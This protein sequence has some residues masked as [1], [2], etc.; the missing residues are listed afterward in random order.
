MGNVY[1][2]RPWLKNYDKHVPHKLKYE[3]KSFTELFSEVVSRYPDKTALIYLGRSITFREVD[4]LS[5]QIAHFLI[6]AGLKPDDVVGLHLPNL[7]AHYIA[8][9]GAQKAGCITTGLSPL[10]TAHEMAHQLKDSDTKVIFTVDVLYSKVAEVAGKAPF[11]TVVVSEIADFLPGVKRVLGKLLKKIPTAEVKPIAGKTV[12]RFMEIMKEMPK[13]PVAVRRSFDDTIFMMYTGGT[14]GPAKGALLTQRSYMSNR[15]Q[16]LAWVDLHAEDI[17]LSA[18]PLFHIAG[19]ALGGF[20]LTHGITQ[21]CVPNPRDTHFLI[22]AL[23]KYRPTFVVNVPTVFF[24]LLKKP[25]FKA[26]DLK[27]HLKWCMS[28]AAP[29]PAENIKELESI[30]GEGNFIELYGMT[31]MSPV[32]ICNPLK[33]RKKPAS[34]GMPFPDT[35]VQ[36]LDTATGNPV[37]PG[38]PGEIVIRGPQLMRGYFNKPEETAN[39]VRDGWMHTGDVAK[40]DEDGYFYLVDRVKDM[41]IVSGFKVFTRELDEILVTHRDV[42]MAA[43]IGLADPERPGSERVGCAIVLHEGVEKTDAKKEEIRAFLKERIA[44]Y[45]M[46]RVIEFMDELP[47]SGVG[48][49]LK[50]ELKKMMTV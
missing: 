22:E 43:S 1:L 9:L 3:E 27:G 35:E 50:R 36:L 19:L 38:E 7:P 16:M 49:V 12:L 5:N 29:F 15:Q 42:Q 2:E 6:R 13:D 26:L 17:A 8:V 34:V 20:S 39:A 33:G 44:P 10:L 14:T 21:I 32:M 30:I 40:M 28:A 45:K 47:V 4:I 25:D 41:V 48:K 18:F 31:E 24:E 37:A 11:S 46:P 23:K